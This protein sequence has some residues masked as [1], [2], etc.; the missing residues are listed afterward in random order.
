[1]VISIN[2][3]ADHVALLGIKKRR[4]MILGTIKKAID[5]ISAAGG[6]KANFQ[7]LF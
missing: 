6:L 1:V 2:F 7:L 4:V 5:D 3:W